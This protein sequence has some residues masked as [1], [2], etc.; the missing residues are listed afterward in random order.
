MYTVAWV[1]P[2]AYLLPTPRQCLPTLVACFDS[3]YEDETSCPVIH[4]ALFCG[5][6]VGLFTV[7]VYHQGLVVLIYHRKKVNIGKVR[8]VLCACKVLCKKRKTEDNP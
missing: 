8:W 3:A 5:L 2:N 7:Q 4:G 1:S 6:S